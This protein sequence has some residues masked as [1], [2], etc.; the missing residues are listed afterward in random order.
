MKKWE[1]T[2]IDPR[3]IEEAIVD[4]WDHFDFRRKTINLIAD[5]Q[6]EENI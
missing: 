1:V 5:E 3:G 6:N 2:N 4:S